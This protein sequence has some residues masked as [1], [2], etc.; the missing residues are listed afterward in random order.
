MKSFV[1]YDLKKIKLF[2]QLLLQSLKSYIFFF[3]L[4]IITLGHC[5]WGGVYDEISLENMYIK[6]IIISKTIE[7]DYNCK[8]TESWLNGT[9]WHWMVTDIYLPKESVYDR[10]MQNWKIMLEGVVDFFLSFIDILEIFHTWYH[11][12]V[13]KFP[14]SSY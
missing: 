3:T 8:V 12:Y 11:I 1:F 10:T 4:M 9:E 6:L 5:P 13:A 2:K 14:I 7:S